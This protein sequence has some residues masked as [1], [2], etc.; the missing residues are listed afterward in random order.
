MPEFHLIIFLCS[1]AN[2]RE[3][4]YGRLKWKFCWNWQ[5]SIS[6]KNAELKCVSTERLNWANL[7]KTLQLQGLAH[8][9]H[10]L[11]TC[12]KQ[13]YKNKLD[14]K[15]SAKFHIQERCNLEMSRRG[16]FLQKCRDVK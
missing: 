13:W 7:S 12:V 8:I 10:T 16:S 2:E 4:L 6:Q 1:A 9:L 15:I 11:E 14:D 5:K 3:S